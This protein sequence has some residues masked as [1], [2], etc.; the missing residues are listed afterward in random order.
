MRTSNLFCSHIPQLPVAA[1]AS[2]PG[3]KQACL[4]KLVSQIGRH[5]DALQNCLQ[6]L[7]SALVPLNGAVGQVAAIVQIEETQPM[8]R[9]GPVFTSLPLHTIAAMLQR[10]ESMH[11]SELEIKKVVVD[12]FRVACAEAQQRAAGGSNDSLS[13][14]RA[15]ISSGSGSTGTANGIVGG[16]WSLDR[17]ESFLQV[18]ITAWM[19]S[20]EI[21]EAGVEADLALITQDANSC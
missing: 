11:A 6:T 8:L 20:P 18:H 4:T 3:L 10:V 9:R 13:Q 5:L 14:S 15:Q 17:V 19:L 2:I 16:S 12:D 21:D 1:L 7:E